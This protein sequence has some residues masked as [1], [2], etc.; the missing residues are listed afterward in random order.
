V[1]I[2]IIIYVNFIFLIK[3]RSLYL[4][5]PTTSA[6]LGKFVFTNFG[7]SEF[8]GKIIVDNRSENP[9]IRGKILDLVAS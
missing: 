3:S 8:G 9:Q 6:N 4:Y 2:I 1:I 7:L 5:G